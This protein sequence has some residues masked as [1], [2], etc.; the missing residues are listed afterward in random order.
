MLYLYYLLI[1]KSSETSP[2]D[3]DRSHLLHPQHR[4]KNRRRQVGP[5]VLRDLCFVLIHT[6]AF[7]V[8]HPPPPFR[9]PA[10]SCRPLCIS[11]PQFTPVREIE[12]RCRKRSLHIE[13]E[14]PSRRLRRDAP[15]TPH[16]PRLSNT[17]SVLV[18]TRLNIHNLFQPEIPLRRPPSHHNLLDVRVPY[19]TVDGNCCG[20][21][22]MEGG[23]HRTKGAD[24]TR[25]AEA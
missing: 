14:P 16:N 23:L 4:L 9:Q 15:P 2:S 13:L 11:W 19:G 25:S 3:L 1:T 12:R 24:A 5:L 7:R 10:R 8:R 21:A 22:A 6:C 20:S 18:V 17:T